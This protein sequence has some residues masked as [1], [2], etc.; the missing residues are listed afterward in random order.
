M[1][2]PP[3]PDVVAAVPELAGYRRTT[4]RL[5]PRRGTSRADDSQLGGPLLVDPDEPW[6]TCSAAHRGLAD[7]REV[8]LGGQPEPMVAVARLWRRDVPELPFRDDEDLCQ[9]LW[10]PLLHSLAF[11]DCLPNVSIRWSAGGAPGLR[12]RPAPPSSRYAAEIG[13]LPS[14]CTVRAERVT[15]YPG[16]YEMPDALAATATAWAKASGWNFWQ[17]LG[18]APGTKVGGWARW[19]YPALPYLCAAGHPMRH[20]M[21]V[22]G[23]EYDTLSRAAWQPMDEPPDQGQH[24]AGLRFGDGGNLYIL[25][26]DDCPDRPIGWVMEH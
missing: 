14:P 23:R 5:H 21:T 25:V 16:V 6:P 7:G 15:E 17:V 13:Y 18:P 4:V 24:D 11:G 2:T 8:N 22:A 20:L 26:C 12:P 3:H 1:R 10:C 9:V 19:L